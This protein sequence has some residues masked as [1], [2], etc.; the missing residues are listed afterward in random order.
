VPREGVHHFGEFGFQSLSILCYFFSHFL[1]LI[2]SRLQGLSHKGY[3][4]KP[5]IPEARQ[6]NRLCDEAA[7]KKKD[8][9][10][11]A[12]ARKRDREEKNKKQCKIA[13]NEGC[14]PPPK[15]ESTEEEDS[16]SGGVDFSESDDLEVVTGASPLPAHRGA[17]GEGLSMALG[18]A[19]LVP[20]SLV[21]ASTARVERRSPMPTAGRRSPAPAASKRSPRRRRDKGCLRRRRVGDHPRPRCRRAAGGPRRARG[22]P[23]GWPRGFRPIRGRRPRVSCQEASVCHGPGGVALANA[24]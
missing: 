21:V 6:A 20:R 12:A 5:P 17:G 14:P 4:S 3:V 2:W 22:H 7:K 9:A 23:H 15:P 11:E 18:E 24:A 8:A 16:S 13:L 1:P 19:R 10:K